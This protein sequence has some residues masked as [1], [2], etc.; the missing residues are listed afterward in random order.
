MVSD[1]G[2]TFKAAAKVIQSIVSHDNVQQYLAGLGVQW[3]FNLPKAPWWGG[4]FERLIKSTKRCLRKVIGQAK[5]SYDELSTALIEVEA[6]LNSRPLSHVTMDDLD[7]PLTPSHLLTGRRILSLPDHLCCESV[8]EEEVV[9]VG[10]DHLTRRARHLNNTI[11]QFWQRW[12]KE[13]LLELR[14]THRYHRGHTNPPKVSA[15]DVIIVHTKDQPRGFWRL[16]RVK[17]VLTGQDGGIRGVVLRVAG[18]GRQASK[19]R[20]ATSL[21]RPIQLVYPLEISLPRQES[22]KDGSTSSAQEQE[23]A[24]EPSD[25]THDLSQDEDDSTCMSQPL[26]RPRRAAA[27]EARDRLMAQALSEEL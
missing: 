8:E 25:S 17:E 6:V 3:I 18:K 11:N 26:R 20:Q 16:G 13:Y 23:A 15:D 21:R 4:I 14:E 12:R 24:P 7:E 19:G 10:R 2:K 5:L 27:Q 1:N 9:D 22:E